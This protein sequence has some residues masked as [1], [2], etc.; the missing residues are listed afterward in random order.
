MTKQEYID[1]LNAQLRDYPEDFRNDIL[2]AFEGHFQEGLNAGQTEDEIVDNLG[3][4]EEVAENIRMMSGPAEF[5]REQA[6]PYTEI[7]QNI[8][9]IGRTL[10]ETI[11]TVADAVT[12][13]LN[14][15]SERPVKE[16][17]MLADSETIVIRTHRAVLDMEIISS[18]ALRYEFE[19]KTNLFSKREAQLYLSQNSDTA[20]FDIEDGS[21]WLRIAIPDSVKTVEFEISG[22]D[23]RFHDVKLQRILG[24]A[25]SADIAVEQAYAQIVTLRTSSGDIR[26]TDTH[27]DQLEAIA[28]SG[29]IKLSHT[30]GNAFLKCSSGDI[31]V[32]HHF[33]NELNASAASGDLEAEPVHI[34]RIT[35]KTASGDIELHS[36][37]YPERIELNSSSGDIDCCLDNSDYT[38]ELSSISGDIDLDNH[39]VIQRTARH[40]IT[41]G[42]GS[43]SVSIHSV[44]GDISLE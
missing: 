5:V 38:A 28:V 12:E 40:R 27:I 35:M 13:S 20:D 32:N 6:D 2:E 10:G 15:R 11:R 14:T 4:V 16:M 39:M 3:T 21:A 24:S 23:V 43:G 30:E 29:D 41:A 18:D 19:P 31:N 26:I 1:A 8:S 22:G 9:E 37:E 36:T 7:R 42:T 25:A 34:Q 33:G 44:S 17:K